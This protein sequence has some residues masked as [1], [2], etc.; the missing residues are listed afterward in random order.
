MREAGRGANWRLV[1]RSPNGQKDAKQRLPRVQYYRDTTKGTEVPQRST[2]KTACVPFCRLLC[3]PSLLC[4]LRQ[5]PL[6]V[7]PRSSFAAPDDETGQDNP[8]QPSFHARFHSPDPSNLH[9]RHHVQDGPGVVQAS[10]WPCSTSVQ[11]LVI[12]KELGKVPTTY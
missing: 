11:G 8:F 3:L 2:L 9:H 10:P 4:I 1:R 5:G 6:R 7:V 12:C